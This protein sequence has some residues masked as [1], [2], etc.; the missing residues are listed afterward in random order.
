MSKCKRSKINIPNWR[1]I[2]IDNYIDIKWYQMRQV[3]KIYLHY[4]II[5][6]HPLCLSLDVFV[7]PM[8]KE[9][10]P[11]PPLKKKMYDWI[12]RKITANLM[13]PIPKI[14][15]I[16]HWSWGWI[17]VF[18]TNCITLLTSCWFQWPV[19]LSRTN[20]SIH[21]NQV[22]SN[23]EW[24]TQSQTAGGFTKSGEFPSKDVCF[25]VFQGLYSVVAKAGDSFS[26]TVARQ[27]KLDT[28][29]SAE[30]FPAKLPFKTIRCKQLLQVFF[31]LPHIYLCRFLSC[32]PSGVLDTSHI[33]EFQYGWSPTA[34]ILLRPTDRR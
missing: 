32:K 2:A 30:F 19:C 31:C 26:Y 25:S 14:T 7:L 15:S 28:L 23:L 22:V 13:C 6:W 1:S 8:E 17:W 3:E 16:H 18:H 24:T 20:L 21:W 12:K 4:Y 29:S 34:C 27:T 11:P 5:A 10:G 9:F 33:A